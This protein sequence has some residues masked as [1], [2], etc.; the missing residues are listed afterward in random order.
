MKDV[1]INWFPYSNKPSVTFAIN[2]RHK[3]ITNSEIIQDNLTKDTIKDLL[4]ADTINAFLMTVTSP[5]PQI[6]TTE[7][8]KD[9]RLQIIS[10]PETDL[11]R[12]TRK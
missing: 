3:T 4:T 5:H 6:T 8:D 10:F 1:K 2:P 12:S 11:S 9:K 7:T